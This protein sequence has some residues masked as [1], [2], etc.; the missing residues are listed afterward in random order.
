MTGTRAALLIASYEYRDPS[1]PDLQAP[2]SDAEALA[3]VLRD[4]L[5][6]DFETRVLTNASRAVVVEA[7]EEFFADRSPDDLL[8]LYFAGHGIKDASGRLYLATT[9]T[10][11]QRLVATGISSADINYLVDQ[12]F[13]TR[14]VLMLDCCYSGALVGSLVSR[15]G[16]PVGVGDH[17]QGYGL[18]VITASDSFQYAFEH[19]KLSSG[20]DRYSSVFTSVLLQGL[21]T[22]QADQDRDGL[23]SVGE[24]YS[25]VADEVRRI[26][27]HQTPTMSTARVR[28]ELYVAR[29]RNLLADLPGLRDLLFSDEAGISLAARAELERLARDDSRRVSEAATAA[30]AP[31]RVV[32]SDAAVTP[33]QHPQP[34][35]RGPAGTSA[36]RTGNDPEL[37]LIHKGGVRAL[38]FSPDGSTLATGGT[39]KAVRI[40][41]LGSG[42]EMRELVHRDGI[43]DVAFS[44][45]GTHLAAACGG[46]ETQLWDVAAGRVLHQVVSMFGH[47]VAFSPD[48]SQ[49]AMTT[50]NGARTISASTG[51]KVRRLKARM[52]YAA[53]GWGFFA[54]AFNPDGSELAAGGSYDPLVGRGYGVAKVWNTT[55][56]E[57]IL[58]L[59]HDP[60]GTV[61]AVAFD[62]TGNW[63]ATGGGGNN[64]AII[65]ATS[66]GNV[67]RQ[68]VH[69][70]IVSAL[71]FTPDSSQ[72]ATGC[73]DRFARLWDT[74][75]GR[76]THRFE[77]DWEITDV[78]ISPDG[79]LFAAANG[80]NSVRVWRIR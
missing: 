59:A 48:G 75:S 13:S 29:N 4:P 7:I 14:K 55:S 37:V 17:F 62:P 72:L 25:Y 51:R 50:V 20:A 42:Q 78:A 44:P 18:A 68:L 6:G 3:G 21:V 36:G 77:H 49:L 1:F 40:W 30:L 56:G 15:R 57:E 46:T 22:G 24:L 45:G 2:G 70:D 11:L 27:P 23:I 32:A 74:G 67:L 43:L 54:L 53:K 28:G 39:D 33:K 73:H 66:T 63:L 47:A 60:P 69:G 71:T 79:R 65:W 64:V 38:A 10:K 31:E 76:E 52:S 12:S 8:L 41:D 19:G 34:P 26:T 16:E 61:T 5:I 35:E 9:D 58:T 80:R